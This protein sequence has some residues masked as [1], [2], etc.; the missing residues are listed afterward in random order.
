MFCE[1]E[2]KMNK[3]I[4][5]ILLLT[6]AVLLIITFS[7]CTSAV[8]E[9]EKKIN[10]VANPTEQYFIFV[11]INHGSNGAAGT[12]T[13]PV[14][15]VMEG[16]T[17]A[18][19]G[20][21]DVCV[22]EGTYNV[23][24]SLAVPT[25]I[26]MAE[27]V[28]IYGGYHNAGGVWTRNREVYLSIINDLTSI[29]RGYPLSA[30]TCN[31]DITRASVI[32]GFKIYSGY[33]SHIMAINCYGGSPT[34]SNNV[35]SG[36]SG[37]NSGSENI[38][39]YCYSAS[40]VIKNNEIYGGSKHIATCGIFLIDS[41]NVNISGNDISGNYPDAPAS[42][43]SYGINCINTTGEIT[44]NTIFGGE[45]VN[46]SYGIYLENSNPDI[47]D[48]EIDGGLNSNSLT[49]GIICNVKSNPSITNNEITG[50]TDS[51]SQTIGIICEGESDPDIT[52]NRI[53]GG[54]SVN[55][56][57]AIACRGESDPDI[58][59]NTILSGISDN[60]KFGIHCYESSSPRIYRN[61]IT[62]AGDESKC[63][64]LEDGSCPEIIQN[65]FDGGSGEHKC[66][67]FEEDDA[68]EPVSVTNNSFSSSFNAS[69]NSYLYRDFSGGVSH[70]ITTITEL[71][72]ID[73]A[74][75]NPAGS[76]SGNTYNK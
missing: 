52:S 54:N 28:S 71:N 2:K 8:E 39:I 59:S 72:G 53:Y 3:K 66:G 67:I 46:L 76:V 23:D 32:D 4:K 21:K 61:Q 26:I 49:V 65:R 74:G 1:K 12:R 9:K 40:P 27:G 17:L 75:Y 43:F 42:L 57:C 69:T 68:S 24:S 36:Y 44:N 35:I 19:T 31:S 25:N 5:K 63:I 64:R 37:A 14:D 62:I 55:I 22:A 38:G 60:S 10:Y 48:N 41:L 58:S 11:D 47:D 33:G 29:E 18:Q 70:L 34:I 16:I 73:E 13:A 6:L 20:G 7:N 56:A 15:D 45:N 30:V 51:G 50:G